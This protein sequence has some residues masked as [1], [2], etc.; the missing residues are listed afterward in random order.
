[1]ATFQVTSEVMRSIVAGICLLMAASATADYYLSANQVS[2]KL[3]FSVPYL[4]RDLK[5]SF[6]SFVTAVLPKQLSTKDTQS[7]KMHASVKP[8]VQVTEVVWEFK[9]DF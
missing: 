3:F 4:L 6:R 9:W 2:P 5:F 1:M 8:K 7:R